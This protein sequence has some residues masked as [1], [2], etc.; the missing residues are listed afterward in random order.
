MSMKDDEL[1][2]FLGTAIANQRQIVGNQN[3]DGSLKTAAVRGVARAAYQRLTEHSKP[4]FSQTILAVLN[5]NIDYKNTLAFDLLFRNKKRYLDSDSQAFLQSIVEN[6]LHDWASCD[7]YCTHSFGYWL[8]ENPS[9]VACV[10][11]YLDHDNAMIRRAAAVSLVYPA[12]QGLFLNESLRVVEGLLEDD[13]HLVHKATGW[14]LKEHA[15]F[16]PNNQELLDWYLTHESS[17]STLTRRYSQIRK[18]MD[19]GLASA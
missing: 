18:R 10:M 16:N 4:R 5:S 15:V 2:A 9:K 13:H 8:V 17:M 3:N 6:H 11:A 19:C 7:D 12:K 1:I 14:L